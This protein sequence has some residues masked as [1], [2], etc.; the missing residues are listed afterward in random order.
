M[1]VTGEIKHHEINAANE[2]GVNIV[3][4]G[5][6]KSEDV[7]LAPLRKKLEAAFPE[8]RFVKSRT[9]SDKIKYI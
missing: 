6:F 7:V 8:V 5:H 9:Y 4:A 2:L 1:L 3:D